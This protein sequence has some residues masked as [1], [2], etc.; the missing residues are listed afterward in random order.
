ML[1]TKGR[2]HALMAAALAIGGGLFALAPA[3][4]AQAP[5]PPESAEAQAQSSYLCQQTEDTAANDAPAPPLQQT[6]AA[7]YAPY[8]YY[9]YG[10]PYYAP[11]PGYVGPGFVVG[12]G[13]RWGWRGGWGGWG[14]HGGWGGWHGGGGWRH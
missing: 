9:P 1:N 13:P 4:R 3:A 2:R 8:P 14:W 12:I 11:Y 6:P 10:Y 7:Y 5:C